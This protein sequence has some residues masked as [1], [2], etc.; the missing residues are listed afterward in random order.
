MSA[1]SARSRFPINV[2]MSIESRSWRISSADKTEVFPF[3][4]GMRR[5]ADG[6][7]R[8]GGDDLTG[9]KPVEEHGDRGEGLLDAG[10]CHRAAEL[11][12]VSG[13]MDRLDVFEPDLFL[14]VP[15]REL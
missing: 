10:L 2:L 8:V 6:V 12:D 13:H 14:F 4:T 5:P 15:G 1:M 3:F 11:L 7:R 9:Y